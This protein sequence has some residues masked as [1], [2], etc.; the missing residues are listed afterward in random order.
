MQLG[1]ELLP[2]RIFAKPRDRMRRFFH[3][4]ER[5]S[6]ESQAFVA[7]RVRVIGHPQN[8]ANVKAGENGYKLHNFFDIL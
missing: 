8:D 2:F 7:I 3:F 4:P 5:E 6:P 1:L